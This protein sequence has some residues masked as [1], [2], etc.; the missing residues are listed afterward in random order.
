M[1]EGGIPGFIGGLI[2]AAI[3]IGVVVAFSMVIIVFILAQA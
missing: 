3:T 2:S 1:E